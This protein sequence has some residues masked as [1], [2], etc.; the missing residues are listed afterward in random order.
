MTIAL[1]ALPPRLAGGI[2]VEP[3]MQVAA[4]RFL[5][6]APAGRFAVRGGDLI[7]V[8]PRPG[9]SA[10]DI[11]LYLLGT[12]MTALCHQRSLAPLHAAAIDLGGEAA[13]LAGP[14]GAGKSTLA[15]QFQA[16][17]RSILADDLCAVDTTG[18]RRPRMW[19]GLA[20]IKL[21]GP[22]LALSGREGKILPRIADKVDKFSL[23]VLLS[24][25]ARPRP[26]KALYVLRPGPSEAVA[27][28]RLA[29]P[30][31]VGAVLGVIH[32][33]PLA[34][35]MGRSAATFQQLLALAARCPIYELN[36]THQASAPLQLPDFLERHWRA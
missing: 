3:L 27:L 12:V 30:E 2:A 11:R 1:G 18:D 14:S 33:W 26:L 7:T 17:G 16:R 19:P 29:G 31:A 4:D 28:R 5:L 13:L 23:S 6:D 20:R 21:W 9:A 10:R 34:V 32:R 36:F 25:A 35:A 24:D 8:D 22:S 15:A